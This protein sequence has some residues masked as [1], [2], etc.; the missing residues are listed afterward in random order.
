MKYPYFSTFMSR[1]KE[2]EPVE[3]SFQ[4]LCTHEFRHNI[5]KVGVDPRL[6]AIAEWIRRL[7]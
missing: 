1:A 3:D 2:P 4:T 7:L 5:V 6:E